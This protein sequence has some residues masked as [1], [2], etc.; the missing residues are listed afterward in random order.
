MAK[1]MWKI[2]ASKKFLES[3]GRSSPVT[4]I[5]E[6][7]HQYLGHQLTTRNSLAEKLE[8]DDTVLANKNPML[9]DGRKFYYQYTSK[10]WFVEVDR[11]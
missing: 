10:S 3:M 7:E 4:S 5:P 6:W 2:P 11:S 9:V 1:L 8:V